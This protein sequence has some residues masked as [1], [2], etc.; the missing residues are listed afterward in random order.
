MAI[1]AGLTDGELEDI[2]THLQTPSITDSDRL[3]DWAEAT[4]PTL[5]SPGALSRTLD[6]YYYRHYPDA[7]LYVATSDGRLYLYDAGNPAAGIVELGM[8]SD[9]LDQAGL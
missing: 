6:V 3:F 7:N 8:L 2:A 1:L 4:Y 5:L 9:W